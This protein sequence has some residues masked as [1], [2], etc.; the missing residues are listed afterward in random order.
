[1]TFRELL[2]LIKVDFSDK[3]AK[4]ILKKVT[5][6]FTNPSFRLILNYRIGRYLILNPNFVTNILVKRYRYVQVVSRSCQ[7]SYKAEIGR[8]IKFPHPIGIV[9]GDGVKIGD[10]VMIWQNV[11]LGSH[12]RSKEDLLYPIIETAVR[13]YEGAT[14][15]GG[16]HVGEG[17][18][19]GAK[20]FVNKNVPAGSTAYG[21]PA[22][23]KVV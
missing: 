9:I 20:S 16:V 18:I 4:S 8:N 11:T 21:I 23:I 15:V 10:G 7:I 5:V 6:Y 14:I 17:A 3:N 2:W 19:I 1:M 13:I 22:K 12:G